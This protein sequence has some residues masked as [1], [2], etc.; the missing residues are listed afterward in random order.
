MP[1]QEM[2][3]RN[4]AVRLLDE[5]DLIDKCSELVEQIIEVL[6][7]LVVVGQLTAT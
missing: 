4:K 3:L 2:R 7:H 1:G 6:I 5:L